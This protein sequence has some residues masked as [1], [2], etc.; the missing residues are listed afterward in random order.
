[1]NPDT[2][3]KKL[4]LVIKYF[5]SFLRGCGELKPVQNEFLCWIFKGYKNYR[6]RDPERDLANLLL[7]TLTAGGAT[8]YHNKYKL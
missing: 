1:M 2:K 4:L 6:F 8:S 3:K 7:V 5:F